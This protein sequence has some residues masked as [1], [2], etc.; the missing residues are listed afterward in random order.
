LTKVSVLLL[1]LDVFVITRIRKATY[2]VMAALV[3]YGVWLT[4]SNIAICIP[5]HLYWD[6]DS[7][8]NNR[9]IYPSTKFFIDITLNAVFDFVMLILPLPAIWSITLPRRQKLWLYFVAGIGLV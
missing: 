1:F 6:P 2:A 9:C 4:A 7:H 8:P 3:F 5:I